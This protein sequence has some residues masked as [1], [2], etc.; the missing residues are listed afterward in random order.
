[1][2]KVTKRGNSLG[3]NINPLILQ[4]TGIKENDEVYITFKGEEIIIRKLKDNRK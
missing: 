3:V 1:M 4:Q 2:A